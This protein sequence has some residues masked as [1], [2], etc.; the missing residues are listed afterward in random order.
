VHTSFQFSEAKELH[1]TDE[2]FQNTGICKFGY[3]HLCL[4]FY[5][6]EHDVYTSWE[7]PLEIHF[8]YL[9][10]K[11][12]FSIFNTSSIISVLFSTKCS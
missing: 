1:E 12:I 6:D 5:K 11:E 3:S 4:T 9:S 10:K 7:T 2:G 8:V